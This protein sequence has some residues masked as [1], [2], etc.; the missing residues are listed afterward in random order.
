MNYGLLQTCFKNSSITYHNLTLYELYFNGHNNLTTNQLY[1]SINNNKTYL[2]L[3]CKI[4]YVKII[5]TVQKLINYIILH[6]IK[7]LHTIFMCKYKNQ[8]TFL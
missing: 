8:C 4:N 3:K 5:I 7:K 2:S 6:T 1:N